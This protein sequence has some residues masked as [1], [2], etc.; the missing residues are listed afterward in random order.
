MSEAPKYT[1]S[2]KFDRA[3]HALDLAAE[4]F[5]QDILAVEA[6]EV[7]GELRRYGEGL[8]GE[9]GALEATEERLAVLDRLKRKHGGTIEAVL[10]HA[11]ACRI[12]REE[13]AGAEEALEEALAARAQATGERAELAAAL[14][15]T[16]AEQAPAMAAAVAERLAALGMESATFSVELGERDAGVGVVVDG[17]RGLV[18]LGGELLLGSYEAVD[19]VG[20]LRSIDL[21]G[22]DAAVRFHWIRKHYQVVDGIVL[23]EAFVTNEQDV[24]PI[25]MPKKVRPG[26]ALARVAMPWAELNAGRESG[27]VTPGPILI[28][29]V[30]FAASSIA[31]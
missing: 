26:A 25:P 4:A 28:V 11:E 30:A 29:S 23:P 16:R 10:D 17:R 21:P 5:L 20:H 1:P 3:A 27:C 2:P 14:H 8:E 6:A 12:R 18:V 19:R 22:G 7:A 24:E 31:M 15:A 9:P 13:L